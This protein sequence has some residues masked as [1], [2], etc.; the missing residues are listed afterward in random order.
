[1]QTNEATL[2]YHRIDDVA[3]RAHRVA[4]AVMRIVGDE[5]GVV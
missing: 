3:P 2:A 5:G 4:S 1:M